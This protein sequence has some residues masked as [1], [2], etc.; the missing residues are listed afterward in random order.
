[1]QGRMNIHE[2]N[3]IN[4]QTLELYN[5]AVIERNEANIKRFARVARRMLAAYDFELEELAHDEN[6]QREYER[7]TDELN[8]FKTAA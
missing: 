7:K 2:V 4:S 1:M 8:E 5:A 6:L 3:S